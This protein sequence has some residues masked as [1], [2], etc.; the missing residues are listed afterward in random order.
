MGLPTTAA[1]I[2]LAALGA[3]ALTELGVPVL[4]AHLFIFYFGCLSNVTPPVSL[5]AYGAA[6]IAGAP[7][8]QTALTALTLAG[9]GFIVPFMFIYGPALLLEGSP[10]AVLG[11]ALT[12]AAGVTALAAAAMGY[13]RRSLAPWERAVLGAA[14]MSLIWPE[15]VS[16]AVGLTAMGLVF[17]RTGRAT[18]WRPERSGA[19]ASRP[20]EPREKER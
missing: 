7:A 13:G 18:P 15:L 8:V 14:A 20:E 19:A 4:G 2:V 5:A 6:G 11:A 3:P 9:A 10:L 17:L 1:Y 16:D 12:G